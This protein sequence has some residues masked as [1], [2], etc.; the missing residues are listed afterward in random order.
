MAGKKDEPPDEPVADVVRANPPVISCP[1]PGATMS[2]PFHISGSCDG[3]DGAEVTVT[4]VYGDGSQ[5]TADVTVTP[6]YQ[7]E[8]DFPDNTP[9]G[10]VTLAVTID[11]PGGDAG[12][13]T[14]TIVIDK[15]ANPHLVARCA[16]IEE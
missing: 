13:T 10:T 15:N 5:V 16:L 9:D 7:Y 3:T 1:R 6:P 8:A 4:A 12:T 14:I 11:P 2:P